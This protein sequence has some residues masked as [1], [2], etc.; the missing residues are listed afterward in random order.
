M[1]SGLWNGITGLNTFEKALNVESNNVANV[2]TV[3][4]KEDVISFQDAMYQSRYGKGSFVENVN[5]AMSQQGGIKL[6][7]G[8][9]DVA[10]EGKGYFIV[11]DV[12]Q[13]GTVETYYTRSGNFARAENGLLQT[14]NG[15]NVLGL[16]STSVPSNTKFT[17]DYSKMIASEAINSPTNLQTINAKSTDYNA[18]AVSDDITT[19]SGNNYKS[20]SA[21]IR[22]IE[23][24]IVDYKN[25]LNSYASNSTALSTNSVSQVTTANASTLM[26]NLTKENDRIEIVIDNTKV[27]QLFDTDV[28]TTLKKFSDKISDVAGVS[29]SIDLDSTS[30]TY[31][32]L[33]INSLIPGK[34][35]NIGNLQV[36]E[37]AVISSNI[38]EAVS[39]T[40]KGS[41]DSARNA[42]ET[43]LNRA[44]AKFLDITSTIDLTGQE[45]LN[46]KEMQLSLS[47]LNLSNISGT[48]E[49]SDGI[50][51]VKDGEN[52][53]L[54]GKLQTAYF[55]NEQG[56]TPTGGNTYQTTKESGSA[57]YAGGINKLVGSSL[58]QSKANLANSLTALLIYQRAFE[59]NSKSVTT[60]DDM[61]KTAIDLKK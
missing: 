56:L 51:Y 57:M 6:T 32:L 22:D 49:I 9:Y 52:K 48:T 37:D 18:S 2:N 12:T 59:A 1:I 42:L 16:T 45:S 15:M 7:N 30:P 54:V 21:K 11:N 19:L 53:F 4:Y 38:Q 43:A 23:A 33:T 44:N 29:S 40:G 3:G 34:E 39:G 14:Q 8:E 58:E 55:N 5:K 36:N 25:K 13:N 10:I 24:L 20:R 50:V 27:T 41:V 46:V 28:T 47:N 61:L 26:N 60:S 17:S 35:V 31:G